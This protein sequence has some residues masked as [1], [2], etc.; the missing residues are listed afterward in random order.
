MADTLARILNPG[1]GRERQR[2]WARSS[3]VGQGESFDFSLSAE[4]QERKAAEC[5]WF[6][7]D[8]RG[9]QRRSTVNADTRGIMTRNDYYNIIRARINA[10]KLILD[11]LENLDFRSL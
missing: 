3:A 8:P 10:M 6:G 2:G 5:K 1:N 11:G 9:M 4:Q 7:L